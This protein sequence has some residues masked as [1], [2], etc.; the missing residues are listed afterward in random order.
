MYL[1]NEMGGLGGFGSKLKS[2]LKKPIEV[3]QKVVEKTAP[4]PI[5]KVAT[6]PMRMLT[7][8][9]DKGTPLDPGTRGLQ[10]IY[11]RNKEDR[12]A[13]LQRGFR[14]IDKITGE[15]KSSQ[16]L[17]KVI[18]PASVILDTIADMENKIGPDRNSTIGKMRRWVSPASYLHRK[19]GPLRRDP[20]PVEITTPSQTSE[21]VEVPPMQDDLSPAYQTYPVAGDLQQSYSFPGIPDNA[22]FYEADGS[23]NA[24]PQMPGFAPGEPAPDSKPKLTLG[25]VAKAALAIFML[26]QI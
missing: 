17:M 23:G 18:S 21:V 13:N 2:A 11:G 20:A 19:G 8:A 22:E 7:R 26:T 6:K 16:R 9:I 14:H 15:S 24:S 5:A 25:Q 12:K 4:K 10:K 1:N 3:A